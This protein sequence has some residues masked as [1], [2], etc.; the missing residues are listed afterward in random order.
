MQRTA[1][2]SRSLQIPLLAVALVL[3]GW[4][5]LLA[6]RP[7]AAQWLPKW[8]AW[9]GE[10]G[11]FATLAIAL[12]LI[13]ALCVS[14]FRSHHARRSR[15]VPAVVVAG[16][17]AT[18]VALGLS[19]YWHCH[20]STH[21]A[22]FQP[23]IWTV[24][25]VK[26]G[27]NDFTL[28]KQICPSP[29]PEALWVGRLTALGA[30][31]TGLAGVVIALFRSQ[32]DRVRA[33]LAN[34]VTAVIGIDDETR[35][36]I[37]AIASTLDRSSTLVLVSGG[38]DEPGVTETRIH[39]GRVISVDFNAADSL[40]SLSVWRNLERLYLMAADPPTN[41]SRLDSITRAL[42]EVGH[43]QRLPLTV[44]IDDPWQAEAWR[45]EQLGGSDTRW[46]ADAVGK[47]EVTARWLLENI[48]ATTT[49]E[50]VFVCGT[51]ELTLAL[52]AEMTRRKLERD[53]YSEPG[54]TALPALHLVGEDAEEYLRDHE[55]HRQQVGF[56]AAG[57]TIDATPQPP[58][59]SVL[60]R[61]IAEREGSSNA[62]IFVD[63][64]VRGPLNSRSTGTR[65]AARFPTMPIH[66]WDTDAQMAQDPLPVVGRLRTYRLALDVPEGQAQDVWERAA[67]LIHQRY[68][69]DIGPQPTPPPARLPWAEL[70]DFYRESNRR[71]V[72]NTLWM[73]E[74][75]A[76]HTWNT[77]GDPPKPL[78]VHD[79]AGLT[80]LQKLERMGFDHDS[81]M[82]MAKAEHE[83]WCRYYRRNHWKHGAVR[84]DKD[85]IHDKLVD[86]P[87][88]EADDDMLNS[89]LTSLAATL[90][91]LRQLGYRSRP[92]WKRF[93]RI[94]T[95]TAQQRS[96]PWTWTSHSGQTM[97]ANAGDWQ[98]RADRDAWSVRNGI[99][100]ASYERVDGDQWRRRGTVSARPAQPGETVETLEGPTAAG[101]GDWVVR[102]SDGEEWPVP[103]QEFAERYTQG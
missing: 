22:F 64:K 7:S 101:D 9:Y 71:Q 19:S 89:A 92:V 37:S 57:P 94:G 80:A 68:V 67:K 55:F 81:A 6:A 1:G 30:I 84:N 10:P 99:F 15:N 87:V 29:T 26:G 95:V 48:I 91:S 39:G 56:A 23:L 58:T 46:A 5:G 35:S 14:S 25:L 42:A 49:V 11:S 31:F 51:S 96:T 85:Q 50:H 2:P 4:L 86:W 90:W 60:L 70:D 28:N 79:M 53:Y 32:A 8:L 3:L 33:S 74:Q 52:C 77:W 13:V 21:P 76:E 72:R 44:R 83:D 98:V 59:V 43:R 34:S 100:Q 12:T 62:V 66:I 88:L 65:L 82:K 102:G 93:S 24:S 61:L 27:V 97:R 16:L 40:K 54:E 45:A 69:A 18:S 20:D 103:A 75:I 17:V 73:V 38:P 41:Q 36:M 78:S 63:D 47:Y